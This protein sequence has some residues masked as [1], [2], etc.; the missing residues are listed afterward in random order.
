MFAYG[1]EGYLPRWSSDLASVVADHGRRLRALIGRPL[2]CVWQVWDT[3]EDDAELRVLRGQFHQRPRASGG[4]PCAELSGRTS[5]GMHS[6]PVKREQGVHYFGSVAIWM[7]LPQVSSRTALV[8]SPISRG[9]WVKRTP[10]P[11]RRS[12]SAWTSSTANW[13]SGM[14]SWTR[15][16]R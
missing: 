13:A 12:Y 7:R 3:T 9:S 4:T 10:R 6:W 2:S 14:P 16:S 5:T 15:A 11:R 1:I 8:T